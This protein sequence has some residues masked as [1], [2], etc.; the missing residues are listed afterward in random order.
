MVLLSRAHC[1]S[2][3]VEFGS[4][5]VNDGFGQLAEQCP[6]V[7]AACDNCERIGEWSAV[8][9]SP[10]RS[11]HLFPHLGV[12]IIAV[13]IVQK[14]FPQGSSMIRSLSDDANR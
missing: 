5:G 14:V 4:G 11:R 9:V 10:E 12:V 3:G 6:Q 8:T 2:S 13:V 1:A 7:A